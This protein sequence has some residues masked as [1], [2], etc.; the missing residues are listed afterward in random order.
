MSVDIDNPEELSSE[1]FKSAL[2]ELLEVANRGGVQVDRSW[3]VERP[4]V[5]ER[6]M[7]EITRVVSDSDQTA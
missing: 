4:D 5:D 1:E 2:E 7:I 6:L 3:V